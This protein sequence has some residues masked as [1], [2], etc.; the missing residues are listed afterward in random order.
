MLWK[1]SNMQEEWFR[2]VMEL[3]KNERS[4]QSIC[5]GFGII[6]PTG[7]KWCQRY[8]DEREP[9]V[10][11]D[12]SRA[13]PRVFEKTNYK[14]EAHI[15]NSQSGRR[16]NSSKAHLERAFNFFRIIIQVLGQLSSFHYVN[17]I[18]IHAL[19]WQLWYFSH[20]MNLEM[21]IA[22]IFDFNP[23]IHGEGVRLVTQ[24]CT[25]HGTIVGPGS[26]FSID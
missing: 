17:V 16:Q 15:G 22:Q 10:L 6:R 12:P 20:V 19:I 25:N 7:Y 23:R 14:V 1:V 5:R 3:Q 26:C 24:T 8:L 13:P 2:F 21:V 9:E 11:R 18:G 4:F